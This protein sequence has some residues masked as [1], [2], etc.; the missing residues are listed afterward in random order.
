MIEPPTESLT[1]AARLDA[2]RARIRAAETHYDRQPGSVALL[3]VSKTFPAAAIAA[4]HARGQ[5]CFGESYVQEAL[6]K[7]SELAPLD[8]EWHF[9]GRIQSNKTRDVAKH[10]SWVH[11]LDR[12]AIAQRLNDQRP[13]AAAPLN[14]CIEINVDDESSKAGV[15]LAALPELAHAIAGL[16]RLRLRG[17]MALPAPTAEF[18]LQKAAFTHAHAAMEDL[19]HHGL[20]LD[21]LSMG[22]SGDLEAAVAAGA[23]IVRIGTALFGPRVSAR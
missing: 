8:I 21:T 4:L 14:V 5:R 11:G 1:L 17:L 19:R 7:I 22:T 23:T 18:A 3:A 6:V 15:S 9:I 12:L 20:P 16:P 10:F 2:L 13:A